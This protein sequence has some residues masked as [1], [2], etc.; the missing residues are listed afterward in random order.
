MCESGCQ[1]SKAI[2]FVDEQA[3]FE[4]MIGEA[5][6]P[7]Q[8]SLPERSGSIGLRIVSTNDR[9]LTKVVD[10]GPIENHFQEKANQKTS[11]LRKRSF[12]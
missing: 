2:F 5:K 6:N 4:M 7:S 12:E 9:F 8:E 3:L 1:K 10:C 11:S